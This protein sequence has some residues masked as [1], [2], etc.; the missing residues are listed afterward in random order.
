L[1]IKDKDIDMPDEFNMKKITTPLLLYL[2]KKEMKS[3]RLFL[4]RCVLTAHRLKKKIDPEFPE[5][6]INLTALPLWVYINLKKAIG[7]KKAFE[8]MRIVILTAGVAKQSILFDTVR[9]ERTFENFI[10][11]ELEINRTG[12]T[13]WNTLE[14][15]EQTRTKFEIKITRCLYHELTQSLGI[16][17]L[18]PIVCQVDNAVFNSYLPEQMTF[19]R[20]GLGQRIADGNKECHFIWKINP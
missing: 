4:F 9:K 15:V 19:H 6:L 14:I 10:Q 18:T 13:R 11:Q 8:V 12:T 16:P 20:N 1:K 5:E 17:E 7:P 3:P 2:L